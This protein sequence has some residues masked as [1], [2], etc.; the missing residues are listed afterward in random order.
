MDD[1]IEAIIVNYIWCL[2]LYL[3]PQS[4]WCEVRLQDKDHPR[5]QS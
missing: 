5:W 1:N 3:R 2:R 4:H